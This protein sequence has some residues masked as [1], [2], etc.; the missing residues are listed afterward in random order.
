MKEECNH[1][2]MEKQARARSG[3]A[4]GH[5]NEFRFYRKCSQMT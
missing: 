1:D 5:G 3:G 4:P 2:G